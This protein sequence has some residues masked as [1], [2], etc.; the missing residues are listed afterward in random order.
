MKTYGRVL[1]LSSILFLAFWGVRAH[2]RNAFQVLRPPHPSGVGVIFVVSYG[3]NS[4]S[5]PVFPAF[6]DAAFFSPFV[7]DRQTVFLIH[8]RDP[9]PG[10][11]AGIVSDVR[12]AVRN[13]REHAAEYGV[14]PDRIGICGMS[15]GGHL[16]ATVANLEHIR[17]VAAF[18][19]PTDFVDYSAPESSVARSWALGAYLAGYLGGADRATLRAFS[20]YFA[21][22]RSTPPTLL[23]QGGAD[24]IVPPFQATHYA[25]ALQAAGVP[26]RLSWRPGRG[27]GWHD[28]RA[29]FAQCAAWFDRYCR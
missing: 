4:T 9:G 24:A 29:D 19:P 18:A 28:Y 21:V 10:A 12:R 22:T 8:H 27:H 14:N 23:I 25:A 2:A 26:F 6:N 11:M 13:V 5:K 17:A 20:P 7:Q 3:W 16:A 15:S 1:A